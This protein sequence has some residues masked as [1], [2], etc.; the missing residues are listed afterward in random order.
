M[1]E[2]SPREACG[3]LLGTRTDA[4][5]LVTRLTPVPNIAHE[6]DA[7][8]LDPIAWRSEE[9]A[10]RRE[11]IEMLG[12][13]HSHPSSSAEPSARDHAGAQEG[14]SHAISAGRGERAIRSFYLL[15]GNFLEQDLH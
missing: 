5:H 12:I 15:S 2:A 3:L 6:A 14:W 9:L 8:R 1:K 4:E 13:W 11:G 7:F 10:A